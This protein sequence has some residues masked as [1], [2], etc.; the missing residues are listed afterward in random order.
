MKLAPVYRL[1]LKQETSYGMNERDNIN[2]RKY[3][4]PPGAQQK[5]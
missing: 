3:V 4:K 2:N 1:L 5:S